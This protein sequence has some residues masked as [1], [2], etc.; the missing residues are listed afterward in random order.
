MRYRKGQANQ[1]IIL[2]GIIVIVL[3]MIA[4]GWSFIQNIGV[5]EQKEQEVSGDV[6]DVSSRVAQLSDKCWQQAGNGESPYHID[7]FKVNVRNI[8]AV[9]P[10]KVREKLQTLP[11]DRLEMSVLPRDVGPVRISYA[12]DD[13]KIEVSQFN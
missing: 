1:F 11:K 7:C 4:G 5:P 13:Q 6:E 3:G 10:N 12:P 9:E 2:A 8:K